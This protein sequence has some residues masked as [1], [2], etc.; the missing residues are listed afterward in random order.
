MAI[1]MIPGSTAGM[2]F[3]P[4]GHRATGWRLPRLLAWAATGIPP[5]GRHRRPETRSPPGRMARRRSRT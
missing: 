5:H 3:Y 2:V 1:A 4:G